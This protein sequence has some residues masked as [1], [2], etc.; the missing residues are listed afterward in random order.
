ML[1][2]I[3]ATIEKR[4]P[5]EWFRLLTL[6][7]VFLLVADITS[8]VRGK[9][10][11]FALV[12]TSLALGLCLMEAAANIFEPK[13]LVNMEHGWSVPQPVIGWGPGHAGRFHMEK[14]DPESGAA[15]F[16]VDYTIDANLLRQ[17]KSCETGPAIVF[18]G[19]SFTFGYGVNDDETLPQFFADALDRK[20]RVLNLGFPAYGPQ[21]FLRELESGRFDEVIGP[22]PKLFIFLTAAWHAERTACKHRFSAYAPHYAIENG[23]VVFQ[24]PCNEGWSLWLREWAENS[25]AYRWVVEPF[26]HKVTHEDVELYIRVMLALRS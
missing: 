21:H 1:L 16:N 7:L 23:R 2:A 15:I 22:Q 6:I 5:W 3:I 11:D 4:Q 24:G 25:A 12:L 8:L 19:C 20:Q 17:T 10:R 18:F 14:I 13:T 26:W 9:W